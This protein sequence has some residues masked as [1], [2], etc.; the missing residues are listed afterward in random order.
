MKKRI[1]LTLLVAVVYL[2]HQD[3]WNWKRIEPLVLGFLPVGLAYHVGF[4][5][6]AAGTM[7]V[8]VHFAWPKHLEAEPGAKPQ[9][10][11][12]TK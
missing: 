8:L 3:F 7:A 9:N 4:S 2:L 1:L 11:K 6:L 5:I 10:R 12:D